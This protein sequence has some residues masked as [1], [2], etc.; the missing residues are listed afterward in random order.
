MQNNKEL[1]EEDVRKA[2]NAILASTNTKLDSMEFTL[3]GLSPFH[4]AAFD[5]AV[6]K[7]ADELE[8]DEK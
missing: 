3:L 1:T 2:V 8:K 7:Y 4:Q 5:N 6:R